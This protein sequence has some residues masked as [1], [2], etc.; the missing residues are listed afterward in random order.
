VGQDMVKCV[1]GFVRFAENF[2]GV[3]VNEALTC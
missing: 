1:D 2:E 3:Q